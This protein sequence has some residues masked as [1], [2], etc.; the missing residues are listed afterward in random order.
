LGLPEASKLAALV[1]GA[2]EQAASGHLTAT[3]KEATS[4][5]ATSKEATSPSEDLLAA[6]RR[7]VQPRLAQVVSLSE[8]LTGSRRDKEKNA[9]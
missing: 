7:I 4:P 5:G 2:L 1:I 9:S 8:R 6:L 3:P